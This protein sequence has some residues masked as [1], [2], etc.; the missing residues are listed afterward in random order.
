MVAGRRAG[1]SAAALILASAYLT[2]FGRVFHLLRSMTTTPPPLVLQ[3]AEFV[4]HGRVQGVFF[5]KYTAEKAVALGLV[6]HVRNVKSGTER[7]V[8]GVVEGPESRVKDMKVWL[9]TT[10][11]PSSRVDRVDWGV[12]EVEALSYAGF[13]IRATTASVHVQ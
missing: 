5:R 10:G 6:G 3:S 7:T 9:E 13:D 8:A 4:V 2:V 11:S 1:L 12:R